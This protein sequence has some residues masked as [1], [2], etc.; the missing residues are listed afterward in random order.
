MVKK[1]HFE[2]LRK[3][4]RNKPR[5]V[6]IEESKNGLRFE[7]G[8]SYDGLP[9]QKNIPERSEFSSPRAFQRWYR[10]CRNPSR[11]LE[12]MIFHVRLAERQSS[13]THGVFLD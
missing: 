10:N 8:P 5:V 2:V 6:W 11:S 9:T 7:I 13:C 12:N 3:K 4:S 1:G